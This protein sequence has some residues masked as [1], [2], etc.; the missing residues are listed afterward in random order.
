MQQYLKSYRKILLINAHISFTCYS[1]GYSLGALDYFSL[2]YHKLLFQDLIIII[3]LLT[4]YLLF[5]LKRISLQNS[6]KALALIVVSD[7][8]YPGLISF[9]I[10]PET[11]QFESNIL[12][13]IILVF[14]I[15]FITEKKFTIFIILITIILIVTN[16]VL[17]NHELLFDSLSET[18]IFIGG[19]G[20]FGI[21]F[22][23]LIKKILKQAVESREKIQ[24]LSDWKQDIIRNVIHDLKVPVSSI[25][26]LSNIESDS[27]SKKIYSQAL[28]I[29]I[30]LEKILDIERLEEPNIILNMKVITVQNLIDRAIN[31]LKTQSIEKN[32]SISKQFI[33]T[34]VL[35]C[36]NDL[37]ERLIVNIIANSIK[38]SPFNSTIQIIVDKHDS[39]CNISI[40]DNGEGIAKEHLEHIFEKYY[41]ISNQDA[42]NSF[43]TGLGLAFCKLVANVHKGKIFVESEEGKGTTFKIIIPE[44]SSSRIS[45]ENALLKPKEITFSQDEKDT[46]LR[47]CH[48]IKSIPVYKASEIIQFTHHLS[49]NKSSNIVNWNESLNDAVYT[50]NSELYEELIQLCIIE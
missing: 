50:G 27:N 8:L 26:N 3:L 49:N 28:N 18:T 44:F 1:I 35:L 36:D 29:N 23:D 10:S 34:G 38:H 17:Y 33:T 16:S 43:S 21:V 15:A 32:I 2:G 20:F 31:T 13:H 4:T 11:Y 5:L 37:M 22:N 30:Q 46:L 14:V 41:S 47:I 39:N 42:N 24:E 7:L 6:F 25:L 9:N 48:Q 12:L 45:I 19:I 40:I